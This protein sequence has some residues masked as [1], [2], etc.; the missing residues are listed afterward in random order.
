MRIAP[1]TDSAE[2]NKLV[3]TVALGGAKRPKLTKMVMSQKTSTT[4]KGIVIEVTPCSNINQRV[5][6]IPSAIFIAWAWSERCVSSLG[7]SPCIFSN[8]TSLP[9]YIG[10]SREGFVPP[11]DVIHLRIQTTELRSRSRD[12]FVSGP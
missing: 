8:R 5:C 6:P 7:E 2:T 1:E 9:A 4:S 11:R 3:T 12:S 10:S